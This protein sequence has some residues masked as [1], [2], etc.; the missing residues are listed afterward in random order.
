MDALSVANEIQN[1]LIKIFL[2]QI[3][4]GH[5]PLLRHGFHFDGWPR[6]SH[7]DRRRQILPFELDAPRVVLIQSILHRNETNSQVEMI[8]VTQRGTLR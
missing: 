3:H 4:R 1:N 2:R 7:V 8:A 5:V 6:F